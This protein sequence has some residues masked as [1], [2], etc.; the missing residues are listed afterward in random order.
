MLAELLHFH[1]YMTLEQG[2]NLF[3]NESTQPM[4]VAY[5]V[6]AMSAQFIVIMDMLDHFRI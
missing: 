4:K 3:S 5:R 2:A 6:V 1:K